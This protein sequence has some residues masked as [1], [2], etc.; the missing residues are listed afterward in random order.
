MVR[1]ATAAPTAAPI[2]PRA[3]EQRR[4][5]RRAAARAAAGGGDR[6]QLHGAR[7]RGA[8]QSRVLVARG[9]HRATAA[10]GQGQPAQAAAVDRSRQ[11][12]I[13]ERCAGGAP[14]RRAEALAA[15]GRGTASDGRIA[16]RECRRAIERADHRD[17]MAQITSA[18]RSLG[19]AD[20][21]RGV[22]VARLGGTQR[23]ER[24]EGREE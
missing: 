13:G 12:G 15:T 1:P 9:A 23:H 11:E 17:G 2:A 14:A 24:R 19:G 5:D 7:G 22:R 6:L 4:R 16:R 8:V 18:Q 3:A 10:Q 21:G 20:E